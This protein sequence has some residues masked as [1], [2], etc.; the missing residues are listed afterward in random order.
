MSC[1]C[2]FC[3]GMG[4]LFQPQKSQFRLGTDRP[5]Q[6]CKWRCYR[7]EMWLNCLCQGEIW[8][9]TQ[10]SSY[11]QA[12][13]SLATSFI[14][15][16]CFIFSWSIML[17]K[18]HFLF[19][20]IRNP[21]SFSFQLGHLKSI[22]KISDPLSTEL[23]NM[24]I[25][26]FFL[27]NVR[28]KLQKR[29]HTSWIFRLKRGGQLNPEMFCCWFYSIKADLKEVLSYMAVLNCCPKFMYIE[30]FFKVCGFFPFMHC[31]LF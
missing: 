1:L 22:P 2:L 27:S 31:H 19:L 13:L 15:F 4:Q 28:S 29:W 3:F 24:I 21:A 23:N 30:C 7:E 6:S 25:I 8:P 26:T 5:L 16:R 17:I 12:L 18:P 10:C 9:I 20:L 14:V 11:V